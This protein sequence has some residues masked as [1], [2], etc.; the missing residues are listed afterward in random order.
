MKFIYLIFLLLFIS[1]IMQSFGQVNI[2][3]VELA[4]MSIVG[5][6]FSILYRGWNLDGTA[7]SLVRIALLVSHLLDFP[8]GHACGIRNHTVMYRQSSRSFGVVVCDHE[9]IKSVVTISFH[10]SG[11]SDSSWSRINDFPVNFFKESCR[12]FLI[13]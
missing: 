11:V 10:N 4:S 13:D 2:W 9:E 5:K 12:N 7:K 3:L 8:F 1:Q 6:F